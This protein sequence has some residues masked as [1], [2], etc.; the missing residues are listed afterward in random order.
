VQ[1]VVVYVVRRLLWA[2]FRAHSR[3][4]DLRERDHRIGVCGVEVFR[5]VMLFRGSGEE[6]VVLS[7]VL[8]W[9]RTSV[10]N[11]VSKKSPSGSGESGHQGI[12]QRLHWN[13][14]HDT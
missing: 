3:R 6:G 5:H 8:R 2:S 10:V 13:V 1:L 14:D 4:V 7:L 11:V 9:N 12:R